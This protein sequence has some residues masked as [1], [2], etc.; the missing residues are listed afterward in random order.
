MELNRTAL[1][2]KIAVRVFAVIM[3]LS[4]AGKAQALA[5][6][7]PAPELSLPKL[8]GAQFNLSSLRGKPV[9]LTFFTTWSDSCA[10]NLKFLSSQN[11]SLKGAGIVTVAFE[12]KPETVSG[13]LKKNDIDLLT[14][15][16]AKKTS[17]RDFQILIIPMTF[18]IDA[19][20]IV[21]KVYVDF[22]DAVMESITEDVR[23]LLSQKS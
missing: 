20:G 11:K 6:G 23:R 18:L 8:N 21:D 16:D 2:L 22:D 3:C 1:R 10:E 14:L 15:I 17:I 7:S 9:I 13:F 5:V 4:L 12:N 19:D